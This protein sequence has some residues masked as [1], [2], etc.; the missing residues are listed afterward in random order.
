MFA[1]SFSSLHTTFGVYIPILGPQRP[2][3]KPRSRVV[4]QVFTPL[5]GSKRPND[6]SRPQVNIRVLAPVLGVWDSV[7]GPKKPNGK[8]VFANLQVAYQLA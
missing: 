6:K 7:L 3:G 1:S 8:T 2:N 4:L 5:L